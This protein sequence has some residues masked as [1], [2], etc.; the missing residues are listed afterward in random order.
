MMLR[1]NPNASFFSR[2]G[3]PGEE[4]SFD[5]C[6][7]DQDMVKAS[8]QTMLAKSFIQFTAKVVRSKKKTD[9]VS[10]ILFLLKFQKKMPKKFEKLSQYE[11]LTDILDDKY[12]IKLV[13]Y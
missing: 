12:Q 8:R 2:T 3:P 13:K 4:S 10:L 6:N 1:S 11:K 9:P 7:N 5:E